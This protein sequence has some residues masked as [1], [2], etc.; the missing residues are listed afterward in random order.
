M[1]HNSKHLKTILKT[2]RACVADQPQQCGNRCG[3]LLARPRSE[4]FG[5][6]LTLILLFS[7]IESKSSTNTQAVAEERVLIIME[8]SSAMQKRAE[9][10]QKIV[11]D[12]ISSGLGGDLRG[13]DTIGL[14]TFDN[15]LSTG[16]F[17]L[18]RWTKATR[19]KV[20]VTAVQFL[21]QQKFEKTSNLSGVWL[22]LTNVVAISERITVIL[23]TSGKENIAG[24]PFDGSIAQNFL[25]N[26]DAQQKAKMPFVTI[27]RAYRGKFVNF[28]VNLPPWPMELPEYPAEARRAPE[29]VTPKPSPEPVAKVAPPSSAPLAHTTIYTTNFP[30]METE[31]GALAQTNPIVSTETNDA[32]VTATI[33]TPA[34]PLKEVESA[35]ERPEESPAPAV[36]K[37]SRSDSFPVKAI[38]IAGIALLIGVMVIFI[39]LLRWTRRSSGASLIT[40]SMTKR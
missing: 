10:A 19:Q 16:Q 22:A 14:W 26:A 30:K 29:P 2:E 38:L 6:L 31:T 37:K 20:A 33:E 40:H 17:P 12:A 24:T 4:I 1:N 8:T 32:P 15:E 39:A 13:G 34:A 3:W 5:A 18:Q 11:G 21:Q 28:S 25:K 9:N 35:A 7:G 23:I 36:A 27:L